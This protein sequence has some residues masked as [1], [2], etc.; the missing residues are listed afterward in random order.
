MSIHR[1]ATLTTL[2]LAALAGRTS[3]QQPT[4]FAADLL[5]DL[6]EAEAKLVQLAQ[7]MPRD[8]YDWRPGEGVRSVGEVFK[9][10]AADNYLMTIPLG[11]AAP[12]DTGIKLEDYGTTGAFEKRSLGKDQIISELRRSFAGIK[13]AFSALTQADAGQTVAVFG[14]DMTRQ[15]LMVM[16]TTHV[17]EHL[18]QSIAY[19]RSNG[20]V[21][22]WSR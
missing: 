17:H 20:I 13:Q 9:H 6:D 10:V 3:A 19:A 21:P 16:I 11:V 5:S 18:G 22:P 2:L 15:R 14:S 4:G 7:A 12:P 1:T 8:D